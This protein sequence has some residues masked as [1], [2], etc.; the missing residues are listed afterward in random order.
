MPLSPLLHN[1][2]LAQRRCDS[3][4]GAALQASGAAAAPDAVPGAVHQNP[5]LQRTCQYRVFKSMPS[6]HGSTPPSHAIICT[7]ATIF[8]DLACRCLAAFKHQARTQ[9]PVTLPQ[10]AQ[11]DMAAY[12][13]HVGARQCKDTAIRPVIRHPQKLYIMLA[14]PVARGTATREHQRDA[15]WQETRASQPAF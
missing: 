1:V 7:G 10:S 9:G 14:P 2:A 12:L 5:K 15:P 11:A 4:L 6:L 8:S 3:G 13:H